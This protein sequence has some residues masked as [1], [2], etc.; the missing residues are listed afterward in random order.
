MLEIEEMGNNRYKIVGEVI[1]A[2]NLKVALQRAMDNDLLTNE[3]TVE[4]WDILNPI[5]SQKI[6]STYEK[7]YRH[8]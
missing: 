8:G 5:R 2:P 6:S 3:E 7:R 1:Y 4:A